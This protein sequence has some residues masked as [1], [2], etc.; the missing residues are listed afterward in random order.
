MPRGLRMCVCVCVSTWDRTVFAQRS[1]VRLRFNVLSPHHN[2]TFY[3]HTLVRYRI[4][5]PDIFFSPDNNNFSHMHVRAARAHTHAHIR[6]IQMRSPHA[7]ATMVTIRIKFTHVASAPPIQRTHPYI[8][9]WNVRARVYVSSGAPRGGRD[10]IAA[11]RTCVRPSSARINTC[12]CPPSGRGHERIESGDTEVLMAFTAGYI[13]HRI[14]R[15]GVSVCVCQPKNSAGP[16][17]SIQLVKCTTSVTFSL[18]I[19]FCSLVCPTC[20]AV[21]V[22]LRA[23]GGQYISSYAWRAGEPSA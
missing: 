21:R 11:D 14:L 13:F 23:L 5:M 9:I 16:F 8:S 3:A 6:V 1:F 20:A 22:V 12:T 2:R 17:R 15:V 10:I 19:I 18:V 7:R 4:T